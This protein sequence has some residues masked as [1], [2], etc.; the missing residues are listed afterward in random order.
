MATPEEIAVLRVYI[1]E[2]VN[3]EP[4]T[5]E[6]LA[7]IIDATES[8]R[9]A[10]ADVWDAKAASVA[11]LV[12]ISEGGS[13]RKMSDIYDRFIALANRY[14]LPPDSISSLGITTTRPIVRG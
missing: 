13:S 9:I 12:D 8:L 4:Y 5:D 14:R 3:A 2:P 1:N 10:A 11:H 7:I 6:T